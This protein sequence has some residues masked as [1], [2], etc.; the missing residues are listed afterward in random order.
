MRFMSKHFQQAQIQDGEDK[1]QC[2]RIVFD[3]P[4]IVEMGE[5]E[6]VSASLKTHDP[7]AAAPRIVRGRAF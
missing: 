6:V 4:P 1:T 2:E 3:V 7:R 5:F